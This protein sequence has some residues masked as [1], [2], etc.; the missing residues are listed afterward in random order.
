MK[1]K[2]KNK[3]IFNPAIFC[4]KC[5]NQLLP[6]TVFCER[7]GTKVPPVSVAE[8]QKTNNTATT[9]Y[10]KPKKGKGTIVLFTALGVLLAVIAVVAVFIIKGLSANDVAISSGSDDSTS[11]QQTIDDRNDTSM[12]EMIPIQNPNINQN[13]A[14]KPTQ[15]ISSTPKITCLSAGCHNSVS[16]FGDYCSEQKCAKSGCNNQKS[17]LSDYCFLHDN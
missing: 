14:Q 17:A 13:I 6:D 2:H 4:T 7:C 1:S 11:H 16:T 5:G 9:E 12:N 8:V 15:S 3:G 10:D